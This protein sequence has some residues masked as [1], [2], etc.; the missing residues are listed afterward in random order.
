MCA[1]LDLSTCCLLAITCLSRSLVEVLVGLSLLVNVLSGWAELEKQCM[2][3]VNL[4]SKFCIPRHSED[5]PGRVGSHL[6]FS[7]YKQ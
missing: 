2:C 1:V 5:A 7:K 3:H 6:I 4:G